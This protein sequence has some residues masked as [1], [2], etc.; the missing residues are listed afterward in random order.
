[1]NYF[2]S[3]FLINGIST[4]KGLFNP[5]AILVEEQQWYYLTHSWEDKRVH[6]FPMGK[7][8]LR[9]KKKFKVFNNSHLF[10]QSYMISSILIYFSFS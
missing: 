7:L 2:S 10:S 5:K 6:A 1:M 9:N 4:L 8:F 3:S